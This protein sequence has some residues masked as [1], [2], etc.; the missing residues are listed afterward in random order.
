[1]WHHG[2]FADQAVAALEMDSGPGCDE[3]VH[4]VDTMDENMDEAFS[5]YL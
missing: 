3:A 4:P 5:E 1:M 2:A